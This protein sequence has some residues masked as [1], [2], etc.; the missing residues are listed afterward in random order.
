MDTLFPHANVLVGLLVLVVG[1]LLSLY[2]SIDQPFQP[3]LA[4]RIG[5]AKRG[6]LPEY[7]AI[8]EGLAAAD[9]ALG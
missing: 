4:E 2:W 3:E 1:F 8:E 7:K 5:I 6:I 9:V